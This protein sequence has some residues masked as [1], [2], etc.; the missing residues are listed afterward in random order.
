[1]GKHKQY[2]RSIKTSPFDLGESGAG[3]QNHQ[4]YFRVLSNTVSSRASMVGQPLERKFGVKPY[5][6]EFWKRKTLRN[7][8]SSRFGKYMRVHFD[9]SHRIQGCNIDTYLLEKVRVCKQLEN[10]RSYHV[11]YMM[12][13]YSQRNEREF[14]LKDA[15]P[16][17]MHYLNGGGCFKVSGRNEKNVYRTR[18]R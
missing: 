17:G 2:A 9:L 4:T 18:Q 3:K 10:E 1:M 14:H 7:N 5:T 15:T 16:E 6:R 12:F 13:W 11:F 8:N